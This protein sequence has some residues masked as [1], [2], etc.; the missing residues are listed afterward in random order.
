MLVGMSVDAQP[1]SE[2]QPTTDYSDNPA[3]RKTSIQLYSVA[4]R[5]LKL[6]GLP[7]W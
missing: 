1:E 7:R 4:A 6:E 3:V 5:G 2:S